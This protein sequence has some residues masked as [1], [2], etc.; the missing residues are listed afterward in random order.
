MIRSSMEITK[1]HYRENAEKL[2]TLLRELSW[3]NSMTISFKVLGETTKQMRE[4]E[5]NRKEH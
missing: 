3:T 2:P 5:N 4:I 1:T